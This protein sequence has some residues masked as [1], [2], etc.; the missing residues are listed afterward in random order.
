MT[1]K[2]LNKAIKT[3]YNQYNKMSEADNDLFFKWLKTTFTPEF[4]RVYYADDS[5]KYINRESIL[6]LLIFNR[7]TRIIPFYN[8][9]INTTI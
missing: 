5:F 2:E 3:L 1:T 4:K 9:G 7:K 6:I 8:F